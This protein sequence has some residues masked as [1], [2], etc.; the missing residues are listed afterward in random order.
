MEFLKLLLKWIVLAI[1]FVLIIVLLVK[2]ANRNE[3]TSK[4][5]KEPKVNIVQKENNNNDIKEETIDE[6]DSL[7][8]IE[9]DMDD[10]YTVD[11]P[12]T[13]S[14]GIAETLLGIVILSYGASYI[15]KRRTVKGN[16]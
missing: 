11:S 7:E 6:D 8:P 9:E 16:S 2:L 3:K 10:A 15:Y 14:N 12:D 4:N 5:S 1:I 13:A